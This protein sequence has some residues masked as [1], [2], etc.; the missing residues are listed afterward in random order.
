[1]ARLAY[2]DGMRRGALI[3]GH[4]SMKY[5]CMLAATLAFVASTAHA[6]YTLVPYDSRGTGGQA[7]A[8]AIGDVDGDG[9]TDVVVTTGYADDEQFRS[10]YWSTCNNPTVRLPWR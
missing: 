5:A 8:V 6:A 7:E 9:R 3:R 10:L 2:D 1:M 4:R